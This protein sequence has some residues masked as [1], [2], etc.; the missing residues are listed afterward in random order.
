MSEKFIVVTGGTG[1]IG[2]ILCAELVTQGF[3]VCAYGRKKDF[4]FVDG[5]EY[6]FVNDYRE[7]E[8]SENAVCVHLAGDNVAQGRDI[9][10]EKE[11]ELLRDAVN[12]AD[13]LLAQKFLK[14]VFASSAQLYGMRANVSHLEDDPVTISGVYADVKYAIEQ[15][16][17]E[18]GQVVARIANVYG[19][20]MSRLNVMSKI[21]GQLPERGPIKVA[22][23]TPVRDFIHVLDVARGLVRLAMGVESGLFNLGT[24]KGTSVLDLARLILKIAG[25]EGRDVIS[26]DSGRSGSC[27]ILDPS[28]MNRFFGWKTRV[29]LK[30]GLKVLVAL[31]SVVSF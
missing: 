9:G 5:V 12:I 14:V 24:G 27:L 1:F 25:Q 15:R 6:K 23:D 18:R 4:K 16:M 11:Q 10:R 29:E 28:K 31:K 19:E 30:E 20:G 2:R 26:K 8:P 21:L 3:G 22:S 7:V 13:H 17:L